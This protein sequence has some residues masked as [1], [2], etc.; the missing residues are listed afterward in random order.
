MLLLCLGNRDGNSNNEVGYF[1]CYFL[2]I[3]KFLRENDQVA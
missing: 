1:S 3:H 2:K